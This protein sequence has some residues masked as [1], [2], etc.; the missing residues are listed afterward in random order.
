[1]WLPI[2]VITN[3]LNNSTSALSSASAWIV[4][5]VSLVKL[6]V[7]LVPLSLELS[8]SSAIGAAGATVSS[9]NVISSGSADGLP[10]PL[11]IARVNVC[12]PLS[13]SE[14][15]PVS[16]IVSSWLRFK[17]KPALPEKSCPNKAP[18]SVLVEPST[19]AVKLVFGPPSLIVPSIVM[20]RSFVIPSLSDRPVS[21]F[22]VAAMTGTDVA[23]AN[24]T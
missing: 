5:A 10:S 18:R 15:T 8:R 7:E 6:S 4:K 24:S 21:P 2:G 23:S 20:L 12:V 11:S 16:A 22:T 14:P 9:S 13:V 1:M 19:E 17:L 3:E